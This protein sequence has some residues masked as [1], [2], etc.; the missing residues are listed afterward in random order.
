MAI[1]HK[2]RIGA[3]IIIPFVLLAVVFG[4]LFWQKYQEARNLPQVPP[5]KQEQAAYKIVSLFFADEQGR[6]VR[7]AREVE[8]CQDQVT[9]L[10]SL[11]E[12]LFSGPVSELTSV[13]PEWTD[14]NQIRIDGDLVTVDV[15]IEFAE[16]LP[17][18]SSA[19]ML[20]VYGIVNTICS[21][22][23]DIRR[24]KIILGGNQEAKLGHLD[25]SEPL[26]PDFTLVAPSSDSATSTPR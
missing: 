21:N 10:R 3:D 4:G 14:I 12:E 20:A 8:T 22:L 18:G 19:E 6:L 23:P 2:Q 9:C 13:V 16:S 7:E 17:R 24:V 5:A 26:E 11:L 25:L 15:G 1:R